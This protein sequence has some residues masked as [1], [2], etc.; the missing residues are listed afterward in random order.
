MATFAFL[1]ASYCQ[2]M[3]GHVRMELFLTK[4]PLR[5]RWLSESLGTVA[6]LFIVTILVIYGWEHTMRAYD[7]GDSTIDAEYPVWPSKM[8]VP[9]AFS[10]LWL[11]LVVQLVGFARLTAKPKAEQVAVPLIET[12]EEQAT[13]EIHEAFG[14]VDKETHV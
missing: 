1:G 9:V 6:A 5:M 2:R 8:L 7:F 11:R 12:V 13:H 4:M 10:V 3:G 14:D